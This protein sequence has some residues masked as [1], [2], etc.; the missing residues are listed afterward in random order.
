[1]PNPGH[2]CNFCSRFS[3]IHI[4][5]EKI[6]FNVDLEWK[7]GTPGAALIGESPIDYLFSDQYWLPIVIFECVRAHALHLNRATHIN[8]P[9]PASHLRLSSMK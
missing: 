1:M 3:S 9:I 7:N 4:C 6:S 5:F 8:N 2:Y